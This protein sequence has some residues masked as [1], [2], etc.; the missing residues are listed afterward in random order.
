MTF[1]ALARTP[2]ICAIAKHFSHNNTLIKL[3]IIKELLKHLS[4]VTLLSLLFGCA[5]PNPN[6]PSALKRQTE[7]AQSSKNVSHSNQR[8]QDGK[9]LTEQ[10]K[11]ILDKKPISVSKTQKLINT[12]T[13]NKQVLDRLQALTQ[14]LNEKPLANSRFNREQQKSLFAYNKSILENRQAL[15][16]SAA[17]AH[18]IYLQSVQLYQC[19]SHLIYEIR[20]LD[21]EA[22]QL[23][24][25]SKINRDIQTIRY[26]IYD[27]SHSEFR[28]WSQIRETEI[29]LNSLY[30]YWQDIAQN[31]QS[32][33]YLKKPNKNIRYVLRSCLYTLGKA[34]KNLQ[35]LLFNY[36]SLWDYGKQL[37]A[38]RALYSSNRTGISFN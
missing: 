21:P 20:T 37:K 33:L 38:L 16:Q 32:A 31:K 22:I 12:T 27:F 13:R 23:K 35:D 19:N 11:A 29:K 1:F 24:P 8:R 4:L 15:E 5:A 25:L 36:E 6:H 30:D 3:N 2:F 34:D 14:Q 7:Q 26:N 17:L 28:A 18:H 10:I 9:A